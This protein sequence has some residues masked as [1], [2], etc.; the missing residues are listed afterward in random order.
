MTKLKSGNI[1]CLLV[2]DKID[3]ITGY[4]TLDPHGA[5][6][7]ARDGTIGHRNL[8]LL[9]ELSVGD[10]AIITEVSDDDAEMLRYLGKLELYPQT[11]I[12]VIS[13]TPFDNLFTIRRTSVNTNNRT[14]SYEDFVIGQS[15]Q[16]VFPSPSTNKDVITSQS[17]EDEK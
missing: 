9:S 4:P 15:L 6:I 13:V 7:P 1:F 5:P 16:L 8:T 12:E 14:K 11:E 17:N 3:E 10:R 2:E